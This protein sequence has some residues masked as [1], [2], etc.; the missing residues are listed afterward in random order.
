M[1][2]K[3]KLF[4]IALISCALIMS[5]TINDDLDDHNEIF[6]SSSINDDSSS[7]NEISSSINDY[8]LDLTEAQKADSDGE[9][10]ETIDPDEGEGN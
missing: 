10:D 3:I 5:C 7:Q 8:L 2:T 4:F 9:I 6:M 1:K